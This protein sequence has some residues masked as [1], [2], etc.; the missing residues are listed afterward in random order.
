MYSIFGLINMEND[1]KIKL[2]CVECEYIE[3]K[4]CMMKRYKLQ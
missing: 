1:Y 2:M 4:L 3:A